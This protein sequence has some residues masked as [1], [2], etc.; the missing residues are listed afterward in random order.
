MR[1]HYSQ[2][3]SLQRDSSHLISTTDFPDMVQCSECMLRLNGWKP[4]DV[5]LKKHSLRSPGCVAVAE[6]M[7]PT[8]KPNDID[9]FDPSLQQDS[10]ELRLYHDPQVFSNHIKQYPTQ[11]RE[12]DL[13]QLLPRYLS[14]KSNKMF[15]KNIGL[16]N[17]KEALTAE[18]GN[19]S[20]NQ[21]A[22]PPTPRTTP[23]Q[24][25]RCLVKGCLWGSAGGC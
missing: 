23:Q 14:G 13:L 6:A 25:T 8:P 4:Q 10:P 22:R 5:P 2:Q 12:E 15:V 18:F 17:C 19:Q 24:P 9:F 11:Y 1:P 16:I 21:P 7:K 3:T 20:C